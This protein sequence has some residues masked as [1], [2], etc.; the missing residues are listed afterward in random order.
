MS[1]RRASCAVVAIIAAVF[2][3]LVQHAGAEQEI[4]AMEKT[5]WNES[6]VRADVAA[7]DRLLADG[8]TVTPR[9]GRAHGCANGAVR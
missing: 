2:P 4:R 1:R 6:R 9:S 3:A 8:R 7:L 5:L